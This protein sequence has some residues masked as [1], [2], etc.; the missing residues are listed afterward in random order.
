VNAESVTSSADG[1]RVWFI[2][3]ASSGIGRALA[4][5]VLERGDRVVAA[6]RDP[7]R[8]RDLGDRYPGQALPA[9]VDVTDQDQVRAA[10]DAGL[11][12]FGRLDVIV[13]NAGYGLFGALEE[14]S[15]EDLRREFETNVLGALYVL[16][17]ALPHLR[18]RRSGHLVQVSSLDGVAPL[19]AGESAYAATKF[20]VEGACEVLAKEVA[21]LGIR[22]TI[23]E[24]GPV[25]TGFGDRAVAAPV[26]ADDYAA[27]VGA[28][29]SWFEDLQGAQPN[30]PRRVADAIVEVVETDRPPLRLALGTEAVQAIRAK[31]ETQRAELDEWEHLSVTTA[32]SAS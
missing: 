23:I 19:G 30:D 13:N 27:S 29:L 20:A 4:E 1:A 12:A 9:G 18:G 5:T 8:V 14:L 32:F 26:S 22:V 3:G 16:R 11:A 21:H 7:H 6:V 31:L 2:T 24:P 28:A 15:A 10:I 25:R 17:A